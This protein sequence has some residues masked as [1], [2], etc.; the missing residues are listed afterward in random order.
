MGIMIIENSKTRI[1]FKNVSWLGSI[2]IPE[3]LKFGYLNERKVFSVVNWGLLD[4]DKQKRIDV[5]DHY[6][7]YAG[8]DFKHVMTK[9]TR[10]YTLKFAR[11]CEE[12]PEMNV[13]MTFYPE[14]IQK[15]P[16]SLDKRKEL[17]FPEDEE[18]PKLD[19]SFSTTEVVIENGGQGIHPM[20]LDKLNEF[21]QK[22][23]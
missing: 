21:I 3:L 9:K 18:T 5:E 23:A 2:Y 20:Y 8:A 14:F 15:I 1:M 13:S 11:F 19:I 17:L 16:R 22:V 7:I 4:W 10:P 12:C 6:H